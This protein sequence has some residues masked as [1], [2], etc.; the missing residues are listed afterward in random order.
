MATDA[1]SFHSNGMTDEGA[2]FIVSQTSGGSG[3]SSSGS[4]ST[5]TGGSASGTTGGQT[6][7]TSA[8][9][10]TGSSGFGSW[11]DLFSGSGGSSWFRN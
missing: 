6:S 5:T 3:T 2:A 8:A 11:K 9:A 4:G 7:T 10:T 1:L